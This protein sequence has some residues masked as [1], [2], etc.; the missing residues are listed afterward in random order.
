MKLMPDRATPPERTEK[1]SVI[2]TLLFGLLF[3][4]WVAEPALENE[5]AVLYHGLWRSVF[6]VLAPLITPVPGISVSPWQILL[7][8]FVPFCLGTSGKTRQHAREMD[9]AIFAS[10]ACVAVTLLWGLVRGGSAYFAYYQVWHFLAALLIAYLLMSAVN[11]ERDLVGLGKILV[12]AALIRA[13]LCIYF[14]WTHLNGKVYPL[15]EYVTDHDDSMLWVVAILILWIW[16]LLKG[17]RVAWTIAGLGVPFMF[18]AMV[19]NNRRL[20]WVELGLAMLLTY[21]LMGAGPLRSRI[22]RWVMRIAPVVLIYIVAGLGS[23]NAAFAPVQALMTTGSNYDASSLTR[24][25][26]DRNLLHTLFDIGNPILGT[27]WGRPYDKVESYFSNYDAGWILQLYTPH[28]SL[29]GL[30]VFSGLVGLI[31]MWGVVPIG[32][33]LAAQGYRDSTDLVPRAA[34]MVALGSLCVYSAHCY[35][36]IGLQSFVCSLIFG[37]AL[38]AA[39]KVA[40]WSEALRSARAATA[41]AEVGHPPPEPGF[42]YRKGVAPRRRFEPSSQRPGASAGNDLT[43]KPSRARTRRPPH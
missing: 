19:L 39:G 26:E 1:R 9:R 38:A 28:N 18:Y 13:T 22:N 3:I 21:F 30:A 27:G 40:A 12:I 8:A 42:A 33:Y 2:A 31:G 34:G 16:A 14:F 4:G 25:E 23:H 37:A 43:G 5:A 35:G 29:L 32:A 36:D 6:V 24:L 20:A 7:I 41:R 11:S 15:P 10:I 17:G